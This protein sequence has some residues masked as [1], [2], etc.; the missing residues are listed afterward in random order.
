[1]Q[2]LPRVITFHGDENKVHEGEGSAPALFNR[3]IQ[4]VEA[5]AYGFYSENDTVYEG[6]L[7]ESTFKTVRR[8]FKEYPRFGGVYGDTM[9]HDGQREIA[10]YGRDFIPNMQH[11]VNVPLFIDKRHREVRFNEELQN[12]Y[13]FDVLR[14]Y[15]M[16][17]W[18]HIPEVIAVTKMVE[19]DSS[20]DM[21]ILQ[22]EQRK[23]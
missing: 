22:G 7:P 5:D 19:F 9:I 21:R 14:R 12:L 20:H 2:Q 8:I 10:Q 15:P 11:V 17:V 16:V 3:I 23:A 6:F 4:E 18:Y 1:M 13:F